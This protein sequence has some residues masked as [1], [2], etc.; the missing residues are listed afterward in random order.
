MFAAMVG[1]ITALCDERIRLF[2]SGRTGLIPDVQIDVAGAPVGA[3]LPLATQAV[4]RRK[5]R[6][7]IK[8][9]QKLHLCII[10]PA[11]RSLLYWDCGWLFALQ[12][13]GKARSV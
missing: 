4:I 12:S 8:R 10:S 3:A 2:V 11:N 9:V 7:L 6:T 5:S 1:I 13:L